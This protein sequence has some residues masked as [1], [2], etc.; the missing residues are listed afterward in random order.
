[1]IVFAGIRNVSIGLVGLDNGVNGMQ[2]GFATGSSSGA[3]WGRSALD[4]LSTELICE[5]GA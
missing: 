2:Q 1:M 5:R 3:A 4:L